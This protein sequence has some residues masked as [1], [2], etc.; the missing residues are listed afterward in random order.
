[1]LY[2]GLDS[3]L[4]FGSLVRKRTLDFPAMRTLVLIVAMLSVFRVH[5]YEVALCMISKA[6]EGLL[7]CLL[8]FLSVLSSRERISAA[9]PWKA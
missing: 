8:T 5:I 1:M 2:I 3:R 4:T 7:R 9:V 6:S